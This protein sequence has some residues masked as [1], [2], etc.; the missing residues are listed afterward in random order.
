MNQLS[1]LTHTDSQNLIAHIKNSVTKNTNEHKSSVPL[2]S[3]CHTM[4]INISYITEALERFKKP[5]IPKPLNIFRHR[6]IIDTL[7]NP[8]PI[9]HSPSIQPPTPEQTGTEHQNKTLY[10]EIT[11]QLGITST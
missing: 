9:T 5:E 11:N 6:A 7:T 1:S 10:S 2:I 8:K 3:K 4:T